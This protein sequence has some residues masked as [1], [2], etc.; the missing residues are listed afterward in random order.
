MQRPSSG[1][2]VG[3]SPITTSRMTP[4]TTYCS[5]G[6]YVQSKDGWIMNQTCLSRVKTSGLWIRLVCVQ[7]KGSWIVNQTSLSRINMAGSWIRFVCVQSKD[8]WIMN[9]T[10]LCPVQNTQGVWNSDFLP[11]S[12]L[13]CWNHCT[14]MSFI[15]A[16]SVTSFWS[17][18]GWI[19]WFIVQLYCD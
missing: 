16:Q 9:Q 11:P 12:M 8:G 2:G 6:T 7:N 13:H 5:V 19:D 4:Q 15:F 18:N 3:V 14:N 17:I 10:C 1:L